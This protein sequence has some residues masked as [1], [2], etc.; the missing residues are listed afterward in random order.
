MNEVTGSMA[1]RFYR[2]P[3]PGLKGSDVKNVQ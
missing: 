3:A 1:G 2:R